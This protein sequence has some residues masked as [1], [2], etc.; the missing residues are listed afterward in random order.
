MTSLLRARRWG[1]ILFALALALTA[2]SGD[3]TSAVTSPSP[4]P[5]VGTA[6]PTPSVMPEADLVVGG[7]ARMAPLPDRPRQLGCAF[8]FEEV[9]EGGASVRIE[10]LGL[11]AEADLTVDIGM[12]WDD[13]EVTPA[14]RPDQI[15]VFETIR[16]TEGDHGCRILEASD[17]S[18]PLSVT[19]EIITLDSLAVATQQV[20]N[21]IADFPRAVRGDDRMFLLSTLNPAVLD[22]YGAAACEA[23]LADD[24]ADPS[25][26]LGLLRVRGPKD[27][28]YLADGASRLIPNTWELYVEASSDGGSGK[29]WVHY[30]ENTQGLTWFADCGEPL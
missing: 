27:Y 20:L 21:F 6:S 16:S 28:E 13:G 10:T 17:A 2:C 24:F 23:F 9:P 3:T 14:P 11:G 15:L 29:A 4:M 12:Q 7:T 5:S 8:G 19:G 25:F 1:P 22:L 26:A 30:A 18:G